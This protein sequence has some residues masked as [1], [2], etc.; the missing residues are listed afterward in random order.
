MQL[1][2]YKKVTGKN[3]L[4]ILSP[5]LTIYTIYT[6]DTTPGQGELELL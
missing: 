2:I 3:V 6:M 5:K 4:C 1:T